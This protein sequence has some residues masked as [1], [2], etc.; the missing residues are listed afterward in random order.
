MIVFD[1]GQFVVACSPL[2]AP[3][4]TGSL[5]PPGADEGTPELLAGGFVVGDPPAG[6]SALLA[7]FAAVGSQSTMFGGVFLAAVACLAVLFFLPFGS[8]PLVADWAEAFGLCDFERG[9]EVRV[10]GF[11]LG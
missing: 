4:P 2:E 11:S 9:A 1:G 8:L 3:V 6:V 5:L 7:A 10:L